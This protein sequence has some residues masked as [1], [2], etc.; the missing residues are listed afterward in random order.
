MKAVNDLRKRLGRALALGA[1]L[2]MLGA[3]G[4]PA[5]R[6]NMEV[7]GVAAPKKNNHAVVVA[8]SGGQQAEG[9]GVGIVGADFKAATEASL[10]RAGAFGSVQA[11]AAG[12]GYALNANII[13]L[14]MPGMGFSMTVDMEVAWS[15]TRL[16]DGAVLMRK[17]IRN[18]YTA[19]VSDAFAGVTRVRL[20]VE[21]A[22][23][24]NIQ[25]M[26]KELEAVAP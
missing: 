14:R 6:A 10:Q 20:A 3:C 4:T 22:A 9:A 18:S 19:S 7:A 16:G 13:E 21:G 2:L 8:V 12:A 1:A 25:K 15:L 26:L 5:Q 11:S 17:A 24:E 23:R